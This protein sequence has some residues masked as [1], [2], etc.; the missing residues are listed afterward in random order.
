MNIGI[1]EWTR[2]II[3]GWGNYISNDEEANHLIKY[4]KDKRIL[5]VPIIL[6][7]GRITNNFTSYQF[8][9]QYFEEN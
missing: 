5:Y 1:V 7:D 6:E 8:N 3:N 9:G 2:N 4:D